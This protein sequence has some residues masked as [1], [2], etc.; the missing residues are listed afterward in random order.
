MNRD[1]HQSLSRTTITL[2]WLVGLS[3][4][5]L[6]AVGIY[7]EEFAVYSLYPIHKAF[8]FL[9]LFLVLPRIIW[10]T[11]NGWPT[12]AGNYKAIEHITAKLVHW[13]LIVGTLLMPVSGMMMSI[14]GGH[15]LD[16]F[17]LVIAHHNLD[18]SDPTKTIPLNE[19]VAGL[20]HTLHGIGGN[21]LL[22]A[23]AL[24][25]IG[26]LKHHIFDK[27]TTLKRMLGKS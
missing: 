10:R 7:M 13:L 27:D 1:T 17:G 3:M 8:G 4:I 18:P 25:V 11:I 21:V 14:A 19:T 26:A 16:V 15:G 5:G 22:G 20:G 12:A 23:I 9:I 24:H 2:H 6:L